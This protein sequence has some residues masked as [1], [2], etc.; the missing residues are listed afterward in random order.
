MTR[1]IQLALKESLKI[2]IYLMIPITV[3]VPAL[4][5]DGYGLGRLFGILGAVFFVITQIPGL[6]R[7]FGL[8]KTFK[9]T[10]SVLQYSRA[11]QGILMFMFGLAH[12]LTVYLVPSI[13]E[14][15]ALEP[16]IYGVFG[17]V[18]LIMALILFV[19]SNN[20]SKKVLKKWW[21]RIH[22]LVY[23]MAWTLAGHLLF[24]IDFQVGA[25]IAS[26]ILLGVV[27]LVAI[28][29]VASLGYSQLNKKKTN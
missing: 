12:Y 14:N 11:Q 25:S 5:T 4:G 10:Y 6:L 16:T 20:Q 28:L 23:I 18:T 17:M 7:R 19:T 22:K 3:L 21:G 9:S 26:Q 13:R 2:I 15:V 1:T 27:G 29:Q 8:L 24:V